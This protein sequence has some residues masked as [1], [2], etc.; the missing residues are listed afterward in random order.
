MARPP[1]GWEAVAAAA[2]ADALNFWHGGES[3]WIYLALV[4]PGFVISPGLIQKA[5]GAIDARAIRIGLAAT[6]VALLLFAAV[7]P[8]LGMIARVYDPA[9]A[10]HELAPRS[11]SPRVPCGR[12]S[13]RRRPLADSAPPRHLSPCSR[14]RS[15]APLRSSSPG[16][17]RRLRTARR[18]IAALTGARWG[19]LLAAALPRHRASH[20]LRPARRSAS[21][22]PF[23]RLYT[24][25]AHPR[26][27]PRSPSG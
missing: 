5:Y 16:A 9:L 17:C 26:P 25:P 3:G 1:R 12:P 20:L 10:D 22:C 2:P 21:S 15:H 6:A 13:G 11:C 18:R 27:S 24:A 19:I 8:L 23:S 7:P 4:A 14:R